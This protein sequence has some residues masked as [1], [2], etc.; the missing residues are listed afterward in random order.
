[1]ELIYL[2]VKEYKNI[3][4]Q[5]F[6]FSARYR[7]KYDKDKNELTIDENR[8]YVHIFRKILMSRLLSGRMGAG[9]VMCYI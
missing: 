7:C 4:E 9:R 8:E 3:K 5:G 2:W 6:N 1:M